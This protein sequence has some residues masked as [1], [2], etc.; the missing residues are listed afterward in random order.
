[1]WGPHFQPCPRPQKSSWQPCRWT[2]VLKSCMWR[3]LPTAD[4]VVAPPVY[5]CKCYLISPKPSTQLLITKFYLNWHIVAYNIIASYTSM[6]IATLLTTWTQK[7]IVEGERSKDKR[8]LSGVPQGIVLGPLMFLLYIDDIDT[9]IR[10]SIC[11]FADDCI[12]AILNYQNTWRPST[13]AIWLKL[14]STM[15]HAM[16]NEAK[17]RKMCNTEVY[18][19][20]TPY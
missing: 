4:L 8:V 14:P 12:L 11:L 15:D 10:S 19:I 9:D 5:H 1:M 2:C 20:P 3:T 13:P 7:I 18:Q 17:L 6:D 16:A